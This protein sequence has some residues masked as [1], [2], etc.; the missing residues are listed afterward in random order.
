MFVY[1]RVRDLR[2]DSDKTQKQIAE[3]LNMQLTV[4]MFQRVLKLIS[5]AQVGKTGLSRHSF[6][7]LLLLI[8]LLMTQHLSFG[9]LQLVAQ[10][11]H[12]HLLLV[13]I[14]VTVMLFGDLKHVLAKVLTSLFL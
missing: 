14:L 10:Q 3:L 5:T 12:S 4:R 1:P 9:K 8:L 6:S 13:I 7:S 2:E 11:S